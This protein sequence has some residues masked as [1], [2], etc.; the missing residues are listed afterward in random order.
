[1]GN[2][3]LPLCQHCVAGGVG[4]GQNT[5]GGLLHAR[6]P[7]GFPCHGCSRRAGVRPPSGSSQTS[8]H[9]P[10]RLGWRAGRRDGEISELF[11]RTARSR[12][13]LPPD[14]FACRSIFSH[15]FAMGAPQEGTVGSVGNVGAIWGSGGTRR[16]CSTRVQREF[17]ADIYTGSVCIGTAS[18]QDYNNDRH[19]GVQANQRHTR[20]LRNGQ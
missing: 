10:V 3:R 11:S 18:R 12:T 6:F 16:E 7:C 19:T 1:M 4:M 13:P 14:H 9:E 17:G 8:A 2:A 15:A 5:S 20:I